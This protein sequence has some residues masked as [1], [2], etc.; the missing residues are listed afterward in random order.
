MSVDATDM[1]AIETLRAPVEPDRLLPLLATATSSIDAETFGKIY[2]N[3]DRHSHGYGRTPTSS[4]RAPSPAPRRWSTAPRR[5]RTAPSRRARSRTTRSTSRSS[6]PRSS[7]SSGRRQTRRRLPQP[8]GQDGLA[9][10]LHLERHLHGRAVHRVE[11]RSSRRRRRAA[12]RRPTRC[13][14]TAPSTPTSTAIVSGPVN[15]RVTVGVGPEHRRRRP[16]SRPVTAGDD[17]IGLVAYSDLWV[18]EYAPAQLT[19]TAAVLVADEHLALGRQRA[20]APAA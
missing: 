18:A 6:S 9:D 20:T 8:G 15:G 7:T 2:S 16:T 4:P 17:V 14:R 1:R 5:T 3:D 13:R 11:P 19:W 12:P 10:H